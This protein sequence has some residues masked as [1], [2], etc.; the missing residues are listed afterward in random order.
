MATVPQPYVYAYGSIPGGVF[1]GQ[2]SEHLEAL[3]RAESTLAAWIESNLNIASDDEAATLTITGDFDLTDTLKAT[4]DALVQ[5][6]A[7]Y[8]VVTFDG[9]TTPLSDPTE[10]AL[11]ANGIASQV[12]TLKYKK[13]DN[14]D[15]NGYGD[16]VKITPVGFMP[17]DK[18]SGNFDGSGKFQFTVQPSDFRG[19]V[20]A[21]VTS[22]KL[23]PKTLVTTWS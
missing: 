16:A 17:I 14:S 18:L 11:T 21:V 5:R 20:T 22:D 12:V 15:S 1:T 8:F 10:L 13:G 3:I 7:D 2:M 4:L 6:S 23:P 19:T 9:G